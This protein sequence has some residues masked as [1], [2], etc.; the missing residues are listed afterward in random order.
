M[1]ED[2]N[3]GRMEE[4]NDGLM[5]LRKVLPIFPVFQNSILPCFPYF[6]EEG[7]WK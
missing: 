6:E 2:W 1:L 5:M 3:N 4:W 7:E